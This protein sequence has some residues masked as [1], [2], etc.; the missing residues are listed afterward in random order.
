MASAPGVTPPPSNVNP[1]TTTYDPDRSCS[2]P[3]NDPSIQ[4]YQASAP[5]IEWAVNQAVQG[6]LTKTQLANL[7]GSGLP[8]YSPQ[9]LFPAPGLTGGGTVPA[10]VM[11]GILAQESN[12]DQA[13]D[14]AIIGQTGNFNPSFNW[15]GDSGDYTYVNWP[16]SDCGYG[17]AQITTGMCLAG[18]SGCS[19]PLPYEDQLAAAVDFQANIAAGLQ[20][21]EQKW[22]QLYTLGIKA[23]D[24]GPKYIENWWYAL[25]AYNSGLEPSAANGNT[26]GCSPGPGCT[27]ASGNGPGGNWGLGW[28]NNPIN[29]IYLPGRQMFLSTNYDYDEAHPQNWSYQEKVIGF[30]AYGLV[31]YSYVNSSWGQSY[32]LGSWPTTPAQAGGEPP[33]ATFCTN[34]GTGNDNCNSSDTSSPCQLSNDHCWWHEPVT[35]TDCAESCGTQALIYQGATADPGDPGVPAG[36]APACSSSPLPASAVIVGDTASSI[37]APLGCGTSWSTNGG[38]M[39]WNFAADVGKNT[40][41]YPSKIDFHQIGGG[42]GGHYWFT[43]T[44]PSASASPG[45]SQPP[46]SGNAELAVT[47][48][49]TP[50]SSVTGWTRIMVAIPNEGAWDPQANYQVNLGSGPVQYR[51]VN[52]AY[53][54][55][56]WVDLG[57][58]KLAAG[59]NVSLSNVT[60]SGLG[61]DIAWDAAAFIPASSPAADY[62]AVGDSYSS[63]EG[64]LPFNAN[65]DYNYEGQINSCHRSSTGSYA[66]QVT[67]PG[68]STPIAKQASSLTGGDEF[69]F[70][71][72]SGALTPAITENAVNATS[73][74]PFLQNDPNLGEYDNWDIAGNTDWTSGSTLFGGGSQTN[75]GNYVTP[76]P[77]SVGSTGLEI[78]Q[79][80]QGWL[81]PAT[82]LVTLTIGGNDARFPDVMTACTETAAIGG[83]CSAT[84]YYLKRLNGVT[85]PHPLYQFEPAV[86][87]GLESHLAATYAAIGAAAP[88]AEIIVLGYPRLFPGDQNPTST[89][90][91]TPGIDFDVPTVK[92]VNTMGDLMDQTISGAVAEVKATG[93]NIHFINP[94]SVFS[95]H[96]ICSSSPWFGGIV[97]EETSGSGTSAPGNDSFHPTAAGQ[98]AFAKLVNECLAG[99]I[100][101]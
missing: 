38:T 33:D 20:I 96:E 76:D 7:Y 56:T 93:V 90:E 99:S 82:T 27:D 42:Y 29:A 85:D 14:H 40:T 18:Y 34:S 94:N 69:A 41:T 101:C 22:N 15:Y 72:C 32:A 16:A 66:D 21:L 92:F 54:S 53:Q 71:A 65:S 30:A 57:I 2:V 86:I 6:D 11:L 81:S 50:P 28:V 12:E 9:G 78:P 51:V 97:T 8:A 23:N 89:C 44:M 25:W 47:G 39:S 67:L 35:W 4:T 48:T 100:S 70:T 24:A 5:E 26:T 68:Q 98:Q 43:H 52:Q 80:D 62:V 87:N 45:G 84:G 58:F 17:I 10:Q 61:Y 83:E 59:A 3:R 46:Q 79:A 64:V 13:S 19:S 55:D 73:T 31:S 63:G 36:Y 77:V 37:P 74:S 75:I 1:A 60:Y 49:W 88:N 95:G 91:V